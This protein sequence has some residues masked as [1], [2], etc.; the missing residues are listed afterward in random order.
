MVRARARDTPLHPLIAFLLGLAERAE[1]AWA[2]ELES[3]FLSYRD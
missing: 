3:S 1:G 2:H